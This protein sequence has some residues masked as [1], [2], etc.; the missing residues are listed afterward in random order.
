MKFQTYLDRDA[1]YEAVANAIY[2]DLSTQLVA[3]RRAL[4]AVPGGTTPGPVFDR[5]CHMDLAWSNVAIM[6]S[7]ERWVPETSERSNTALLRARLHQG[8]AAQSTILPM[9]Y[10][11]DTPEEGIKH[12]TDTIDAHLPVSVLLLG[13]GADM[14]T[15]SIFPQADLLTEALSDD[16]PTVLPMRAVGAPEPRGTLSAPVLKAARHIH[17]IITGEEKRA[18]LETA[19]TLRPIEAPITAFLSNATVH[20]AA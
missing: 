10:P 15:A 20:W 12:L 13:M 9:H 18:A 6:L 3:Q 17:V 8:A 1:L 5:L 4:L 16:A 2:T 14:H 11:S 19:Q 7:D